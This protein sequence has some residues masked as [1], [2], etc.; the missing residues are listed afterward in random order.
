MEDS[1]LIFVNYSGEVIVEKSFDD[2]TKELA[3]Y[4]SQIIMGHSVFD[5]ALNS[6]ITNIGVH[7]S[8]LYI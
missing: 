1:K 8:Y 2:L 6:A 4:T 3:T 7:Y 5:H